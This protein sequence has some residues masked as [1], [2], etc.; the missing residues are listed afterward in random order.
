MLGVSTQE[1][2]SVERR[3]VQ[4][5]TELCH[6]RTDVGGMERHLRLQHDMDCWTISNIQWRMGEWNMER[7][8]R[9][10][11]K[12]HTLCTTIRDVELASKEAVQV[13]RHLLLIIACK[14][15]LKDK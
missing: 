11:M 3:G 15:K 5:G 8:C 13:H 7:S 6:T 14:G 12:R 9:A 10:I 4:G 2:M 1:W